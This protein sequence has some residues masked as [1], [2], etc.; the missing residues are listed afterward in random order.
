MKK[1]IF[2]KALCLI[3]CFSMVFSSVITVMA[4][5]G[6]KAID[7]NGH[8]VVDSGWGIAPQPN[9]G[10]QSRALLISATCRGSSSSL[11]E[12]PVTDVDNVGAMLAKSDQFD[13]G[14]KNIVKFDVATKMSTAKT[15]DA[16]IANVKEAYTGS[17]EDDINYFY[18]SGRSMNIGKNGEDSELCL[19]GETAISSSLLKEILDGCPGTY[20]I[21]IDSCFS[22]AMAS[23][24]MSDNRFANNFMQT[25]AGNSSR[26]AFEDGGKNS[27]KYK[28]LLSSSRYTFSKGDEVNGGFFTLAMTAGAGESYTDKSYNTYPADTNNDGTVT[29]AE[30]YKWTANT[31]LGAHVRAYPERDYTTFLSYKNNST[32]LGA[33]ITDASARVN[34]DGKTVSL[35]FKAGNFSSLERGY[36]ISPDDALLMLYKRT[37]LPIDYSEK[38]PNAHTSVIAVKPNAFNTITFPINENLSDKNLSG[39]VIVIIRPQVEGAAM[40]TVPLALFGE[41]GRDD[42]QLSIRTPYPAATFGPKNDS[43][44]LRI[45]LQLKKEE[46]VSEDPNFAA[47]IT[48]RII[49]GDTSECVRTLADN[50]PGRLNWIYALELPPSARGERV[51]KYSSINDLF[52]D[53]KN[54]AGDFVE[55]G[56]YAIDVTVNYGNNNVQNKFV[57]IYF[58]RPTVIF[59]P[60]PTT[61]F[62]INAVGVPYANATI[63]IKQGDKTVGSAVTNAKGVAT[64]NLSQGEYTCIVTSKDYAVKSRKISVK[65][66]TNNI[67]LDINSHIISFD[68]MGG[69][70]TPVKAETDINGKLL[71]ELPTPTRTGY[72]FEGWYTTP[73]TGGM[74]IPKNCVFK[75]DT[76]IYARWAAFYGYVLAIDTAPTSATI[77]PYQ[78][79]NVSVSG[80]VLPWQV[81]NETKSAID[82]D[83]RKAL[84]AGESLVGITSYVS[85][86]NAQSI[87]VTTLMDMAKA[88]EAAGGRIML[89]ADTVDDKGFVL[90]RLYIN[91]ALAANLKGN[92]K[93]G[94][95]LGEAETQATL[96]RFSNF[97]NKIAVVGLAQ[98]GSFGMPIKL[99]VKADL[100]GFDTKK[101]GFYSYDTHSNIYDRLAKTAYSMDENGYLYFETSVGGELIVSDGP[102]AK[103]K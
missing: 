98:Q 74:S 33:L 43:R 36:I 34:G 85:V 67:R 25:F 48:C 6:E 84:A 1:T 15:M 51:N 30:I 5:V 39:N 68:A 61:T 17:D 91:P 7:S 57:G 23:K 66:D 60:A 11:G 54:D 93:L 65:R 94:V 9:G 77:L 78:S 29:L 37:G 99:A 81:V 69:E 24:S 70:L 89:K 90:A 102:L 72:T 55:S 63:L 20:I 97:D 16:F 52:W 32:A 53:G 75:E 87:A 19:N 44:E 40:V 83:K 56:T 38:F 22:G 101:L 95:R 35:S 47:L 31:D 42:N 4:Q 86:R 64:F 88:A 46:I 21:M 50:M 103:K 18:Y 10:V 26:G 3:L 96:A 14:E 13:S 45:G 49:N 80:E 73:T 79:S 58:V 82:D 92:I 41:S 76:T 2:K 100:K 71:T 59:D 8:W 62:Y 12:A 28:L 27:D